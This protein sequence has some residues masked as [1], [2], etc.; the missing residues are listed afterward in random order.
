LYDLWTQ[1]V[2]EVNTGIVG[3]MLGKYR[4]AGL[5]GLDLKLHIHNTCIT[6]E[7]VIG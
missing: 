6:G 4:L 3:G 2:D 1:G 5:Q 7:L